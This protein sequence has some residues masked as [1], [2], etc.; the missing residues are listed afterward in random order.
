VVNTVQTLLALSVLVCEV[1]LVHTANGADP[2]LPRSNATRSSFSAPSRDYSS[3]PLWT[4][5][6]R[7]TKEQIQQTLQDLVD[8]N[9]RQVWVHPRPGLM[10]PYLGKEWFDRWK[11]S[12]EFAQ[13]HDMNVWIYDENSYP[14]GFAGGL[15]PEAMP[16]SRGQGI[17]FEWIDSVDKLPE[18]NREAVVGVYLEQAGAVFANQSAEYFAGGSLPNG[19][20]LVA[21]RTQAP[22]GGWFGG[23]Y[24]VDLLM[25]GVVDKFLEITMGAYER[26]VGEHFGGHLPGVFT[27]EPHLC[28]APGIHWT[29]RLPQA[30]QK[31]WGYDLMAHLPQLNQPIGDYQRVRHNYC[32]LLLDEFIN[33]WAKPFYEY[34]EEKNLEFTGHYWEH[35]WPG[36]SHGPD[37]MAMYAW[38]QR[39]AIDCL[40]NRYDPVGVHAQFGNVRATKELASA[41]NQLGRRRTLCEAYGAG[42]WDLRFEDMKRIGDWLY[43]VGVNT[44]NEHLS[45]VTIRGARKRDHPQSFSYHAPWW[46]EYKTMADYFTRLSL[47]MS[48]GRQIN[49]V[50]LIQPTTTGW[51]YQPGSG[52][53]PKID[54]LGAA[55][56]KLVYDLETT[57]A[58]FDIGCEDIM[59]RWGSVSP[60]GRLVVGKCSYDSVIIA[61]HTDNL[62]APTV[63]LLRQFIAQGGTVYCCGQAATRVDGSVCDD[64][65]LLAD[66]DRWKTVTVDQALQVAKRRTVADKL[67]IVQAQSDRGVLF[68]QRRRFADGELVLLVNTSIEHSC[69]GELF[70]NSGSVEQWDLHSGQISPYPTALWDEQALV[71]TR[72]ELP[73]CGS[74]L[75]FLSQN[76]TR[77]AG[78]DPPEPKVIKPVPGR[79]RIERVGPNV[80]TLDFVDVTAGGETR[81]GIYTYAAGHFVFEKNGMPRNPWDS[82]VQ[83]RDALISRTFSEDSGFEATYRFQI[84]QEVPSKLAIVIERADM[85]T[86]LCNG[87]PVE[88]A[89]GKDNWWLD[90]AFFKVDLSD[91]TK[92]GENAV[93]IKATPMTVYHE[94]EPAYVIGEFSLE[95]AEAGF[96]V[97]PAK[98]LGYGDVEHGWED[99]GAPFYADGVEYTEVFQVPDD[100]D[101]RYRLQLSE[102]YGAVALVSVNGQRAGTIY[103]QPWECDIS[104]RIRPGE[105]NKV[106]VRVIGTL[107]NT[108][109]PH[110]LG[111]DGDHVGS[112]WPHAFQQAPEHGPPSGHTYSTLDYGLFAPA[113]IEAY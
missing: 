84:N 59:S 4:W 78:L 17:V 108:L 44:L 36:V 38:H 77:T 53:Q 110:H 20:Y 30:F 65:K 85:Y 27:D 73:P 95:P 102:W 86:I 49:H 87:R 98:P 7:L 71:K 103:H 57:Q 69:R 43:V 88:P 29:D 37:N 63:Q 21:K 80:L 61:P 101:R 40:M 2:T 54:Q 8:Q 56:Q 105:E 52:D 111:G 15:V 34:C 32:Q 93:T 13:K 100:S 48:A 109:G 99:Q 58:E 76:L 68:H 46:G 42:G 62:N 94:L 35:G 39:P 64:V 10:T 6:D 25:P 24:Y 79:S 107:R 113:V 96:V 47:A 104:K 97:V 26:E 72:F 81:Q 112:A 106:T 91:A 22:S 67:D 31:R 51:L 90:R 70:S 28:P 89:T 33:C 50:L 19:K 12:L 83:F 60:D 41:A 23:T 1:L 45:Y 3:G 55:F 82:A 11:E 18:P 5:N 14:S 16:E 74:L 9:V 75:L 66:S 92:I